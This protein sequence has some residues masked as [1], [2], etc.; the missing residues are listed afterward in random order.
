[1]KINLVM[2]VKNE[3]RSLGKC[4]EAAKPLADQ[5]ILADTGSED[6]TK[7]IARSFGAQIYDFPWNDDFSEARNFALDHSDGDWNLVLDADEYVQDGDRERLEESIKGRQGKWLGV[8]TRLDPFRDKEGVQT[9]YTLL[10]R[11][12]PA[13]VRYAGR[14]HEQP[15]T[16]LPCFP[17][18][19]KALH[20]GYLQPGKGERNL[21]LLQRAAAE[22]P[23]DG[24][25]QFQLALTLRNLGRLEES[26]GHFA[27]FYRQTGREAG[28]WA[29]G[30]ILYLYTLGDVGTPIYL[31]KGLHIIMTAEPALKD[32]ADFCFACGIFFMKLV[33]ADTPRYIRYFPR[34]EESWL[35][36]LAL[37][38]QQTDGAVAG[39]GSFK[40]SYNLGLLYEMGGDKRKAAGFYRMAAEAD[41]APAKERLA[42]VSG[43]KK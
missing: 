6:D 14:V 2:I 38:E 1:M 24:Y 5:M 37:G 15:D 43:Q 11:L 12:L 34:I 13:G 22:N 30:V 18:P 41:Y 3:A 28:F 16:G 39:T 29:Q 42:L 25:Y 23:E 21:A 26:L 9:A 17:V 35:R 33:L 27:A 7:K 40:A 20:D 36:C 10:P 32:R 4:L 19:L 8:I 31:E